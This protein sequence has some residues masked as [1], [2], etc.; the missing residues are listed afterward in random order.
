MIFAH[1]IC[2]IEKVEILWRILRKSGFGENA[3]EQN[4]TSIKA[5]RNS[6]R[7]IVCCLSI[8]IHYNV[9]SGDSESFF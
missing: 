7:K 9:S 2:P 6:N 1:R 8:L 3:R 4:E 5:L